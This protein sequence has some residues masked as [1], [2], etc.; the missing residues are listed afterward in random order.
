[1]TDVVGVPFRAPGYRHIF[2]QYMIRVRRRDELRAYLTANGVGTEIYYPVPLHAQ[3]C[4]AYLEH[5]PEDFP[6]SLEAAAQV[7][8]LPIYP[9]LTTEQREY[10]VRQIAAFCRA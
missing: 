9:E 3:Q 1:L 2:N 5:S 4:F 6:H 7:L 8:A 10:V